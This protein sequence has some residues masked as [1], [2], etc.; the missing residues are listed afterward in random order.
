MLGNKTWSCKYKSVFKDLSTFELQLGDWYLVNQ[1]KSISLLNACDTAPSFHAI[2][3]KTKL[4]ILFPCICGGKESN[5]FTEQKS[6]Q[7]KK[8]RNEMTEGY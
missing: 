7:V 5:I 4:L 3:F 1:I 6:F 8:E 2:L